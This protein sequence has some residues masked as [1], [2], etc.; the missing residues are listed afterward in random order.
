MSARPFVRRFRERDL[1]SQLLLHNLYFA[2]I[3]RHGISLT[4][5]E[6]LLVRC[7]AVNL[8][9]TIRED[10]S[11]TFRLVRGGYIHL[12]T[13]CLTGR[14][15]EVICRG[16]LSFDSGTHLGVIRHTQQCVHGVLFCTC[17]P[18]MAL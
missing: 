13:E 6:F 17:L 11:E 5:I 1:N 4:E 15:P 12:I 7:P 8:I 2:G 14:K 10:G 9:P 16:A 3:C 18:F